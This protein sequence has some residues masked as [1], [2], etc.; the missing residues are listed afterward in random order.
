M[1]ILTNADVEFKINDCHYARENGDYKTAD[2]IANELLDYGFRQTALAELQKTQEER[3]RAEKVQ[4]QVEED[5]E[6]DWRTFL[7]L[8]QLQGGIKAIV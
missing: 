8:R 1:S 4:K 2:D 5:M 6:N 7:E 3:V